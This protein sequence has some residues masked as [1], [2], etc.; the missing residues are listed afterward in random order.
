[1]GR[2]VRDGGAEPARVRPDRLRARVSAVV[3]VEIIPV[4]L[5]APVAGAL[6]DRFPW[7]QVMVGAV[8]ST[9]LIF[10][11]GNV[12]AVYVIAFALSIGT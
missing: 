1:V 12:A 10:T 8:L 6:V 5:F 11:S 9:A 7:G 3:A 4:L 2:C